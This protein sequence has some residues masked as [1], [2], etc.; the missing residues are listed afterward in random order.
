MGI[1]IFENWFVI[2][3][4]YS[5]LAYGCKKLNLL[6]QWHFRM[7]MHLFRDSMEARRVSLLHLDDSLEDNKTLGCTAVIMIMAMG[8]ILHVRTLIHTL[9]FPLRAK[10]LSLQR[11]IRQLTSIALNCIFKR[12]MLPR[13]EMDTV[14]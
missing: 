5:R 7:L 1:Q 12:S 3:S 9:M 11:T 14:C 2:Y 13:V 4:L 8:A 10:A 6:K